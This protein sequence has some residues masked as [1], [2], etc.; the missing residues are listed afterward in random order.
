MAKRPGAVALAAGALFALCAP[1]A[2]VAQ[3]GSEG[4]PPPREVSGGYADWT[5]A[6]AELADRGV[7]LDVT[8]P[9]VRT[10]ADRASFPALGG[11]A[12]PETGDAELEL[13]GAARFEGTAARPLV[14]AGLR[15]RLADAGGALYAR[16]VVDGRAGELV[17]ADVT[18]GAAPA[19]RATG[20]TWAGL[21]ASLT[22]EGAA[23]LSSWSGAEFTAGDGLGV[24]DV[25]V[26]TPAPKPEAAEA[27][28]AASPSASA[29]EPAAAPVPAA[30]VAHPTLA[31]GAE[32]SV[33][34]EGFAP[35]AVVLVA[36]DGDTR[37]QTVA[38]A[39]G[40]VERTFPVYATAFEG[41]HTVDLS[42][43]TGRGTVLSV[44]FEVGVP[45]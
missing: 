11:E 17:L 19:V 15:L 12:D 13:G 7:S 14:L 25:T 43:V 6:G 4:D 23:L 24:L 30:S 38:D 44:P 27:P 22:A 2:A 36:I 5:V 8:G 40:R 32:Q 31:P 33:T 45:D 29:P 28:R 35:G 18:R 20:V 37:Y 39:D 10:S 1:G 41:E 34:G 26:G 16:T 3:A 9:A 21:R 42:A